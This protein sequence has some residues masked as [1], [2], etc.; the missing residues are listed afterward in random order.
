M[1]KIENYVKS[2]NKHKLD[3]NF[4]T[5]SKNDSN[6]T[7][8]DF[9]PKQSVDTDD[10]QISPL[11]H[12]SPFS[13]SFPSVST[14]QQNDSNIS[15][16]FSS[17]SSK[18]L[19]IASESAISYP[20][21]GSFTS[22]KTASNSTTKASILSTSD[23]NVSF[24]SRSSADDSNSDT[25]SETNDT[26]YPSPLNANP[27]KS[28]NMFSIKSEVVCPF[29][30]DGRFDITKFQFP[31]FGSDFERLNKELTED[32]LAEFSY[33]SL[34]TIFRNVCKKIQ[35]VFFPPYTE[36]PPTY[37]C[38]QVCTKFYQNYPLVQ[39]NFLLIKKRSDMPILLRKMDFISV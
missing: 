32:Q 11:T 36:I 14:I 21:S 31:A 37:D 22:H 12:A 7:R 39:K 30:I 28:V 10:L 33:Q 23:D 29:I 20:V 24:S 34:S 8:T 25:Q 4:S 19:T 16:H 6:L 27:V 35:T 18:L 5:A 26:E 1:E 2:K 13:V 38:S 17:S 15:S 9:G 3:L